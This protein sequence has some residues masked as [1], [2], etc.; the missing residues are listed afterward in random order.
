MKTVWLIHVDR[1]GDESRAKSGYI[2]SIVDTAKM[3]VRE[4]KFQEIKPEIQVVAVGLG[5]ALSD[6]LSHQKVPHTQIGEII[7]RIGSADIIKYREERYGRSK[8]RSQET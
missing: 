8:E 1:Y 2:R 5:L 4:Y 3:I 7:S 6:Y